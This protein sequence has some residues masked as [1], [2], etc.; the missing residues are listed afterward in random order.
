M[1]GLTFCGEEGF[2]LIFI[3]NTQFDIVAPWKIGVIGF[4]LSI[5]C[6]WIFN[7]SELSKEVSL[8]DLPEEITFEICF[9]MDKDAVFY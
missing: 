3:L 8:E 6:C 5:I 7:G 2:V 9:L 4:Q 1:R